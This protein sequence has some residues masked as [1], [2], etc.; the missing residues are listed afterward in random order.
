MALNRPITNNQLKIAIL[1]REDTPAILYQR[2][3]RIQI[4]SSNIKILFAYYSFLVYIR[5]FVEESSVGTDQPFISTVKLKKVRLPIP[6]TK[7]EQTAIANALSDADTW[8]QSLTRLIAKKRQIKQG[9]MQSLLNPYEDG[10]LK[11]GWEVKRLVDIA[12]LQRG[13]DLPSS[14]LERGEYPVVYSNGVLNFHNQKQV[15]GPGVITGRSGTLGSIHFVTSDYWPHNTTLWATSFNGNVPKFVFYLFKS[16]GF[17]RF[18]TGSGVPTLNRNDAHGFSVGIPQNADEQTRIA[19]ILSDM[20]KEISDLEAKLEK[21]KAL[22]QGM[23]QNLLTGKIRLV[24]PAQ[25][26]PHANP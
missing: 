13:F 4:L 8:I 11:G 16:I 24:K 5:K 2:V 15:A 7:T 9:A 17:S 25:E 22:K 18:A 19:T 3:G 26:A 14:Q 21:A 6:P 12:P 23:M 10:V 1:K 20:D